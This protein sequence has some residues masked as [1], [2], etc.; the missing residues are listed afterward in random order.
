MFVKSFGRIFKDWSQFWNSILGMIL[1]T[2]TKFSKNGE[3]APCP[4]P[5]IRDL[6]VLM[7]PRE[8]EE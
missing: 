4:I 1:E 5:V 8:E 3:S 7:A 2:E 6:Q